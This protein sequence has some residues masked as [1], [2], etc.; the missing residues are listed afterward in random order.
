M[1]IYT[2]FVYACFRRRFAP[3]VLKALAIVG[4]MITFRND[5]P[6]NATQESGKQPDWG[7]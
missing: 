6:V 1:Y 4:I 7:V 5:G 2:Y 3:L